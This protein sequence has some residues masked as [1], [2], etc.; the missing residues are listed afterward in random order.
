M[1]PTPSYNTHAEGRVSI[2]SQAVEIHL[3]VKRIQENK[4]KGNENN[5]IKNEKGIKGRCQNDFF[6][7]FLIGVSKLLFCIQFIW[8]AKFIDLINKGDNISPQLPY[9]INNSIGRKQ[10]HK[11]NIN[12]ASEYVSLAF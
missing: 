3:R 8:S 5:E 1:L 12:I 9:F 11:R 4:R 2:A 10:I 6:W 7:R